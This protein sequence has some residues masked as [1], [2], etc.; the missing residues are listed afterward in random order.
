MQNSSN[1][2]GSF[3][4]IFEKM[5]KKV[6]L[7]VT[8]GEKSA[9]KPNKSPVGEKSAIKPNESP[10]GEKSHKSVQIVQIFFNDI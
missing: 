7:G 2:I 3:W 8:F 9:I 5:R 10:V 1:G 4:C 6:F